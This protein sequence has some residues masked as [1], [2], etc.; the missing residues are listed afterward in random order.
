MNVIF[1][2]LLG[3]S[4]PQV[5]NPI[6]FYSECM[7]VACVWG[8]IFGLS[9]GVADVRVRQAMGSRHG[10]TEDVDGFRRSHRKQS[11]GARI[12]IGVPDRRLRRVDCRRTPATSGDAAR[13]PVDQ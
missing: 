4:N 12:S 5:Y 11:A 6:T 10:N 1:L 2:V 8:R 9:P 3:P 7:F 13:P